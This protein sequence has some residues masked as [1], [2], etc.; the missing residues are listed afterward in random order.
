[1]GCKERLIPRKDMVNILSEVFITDALTKNTRFSNNYNR[2][3]SIEYYKPILDK[4]GYTETQF[5]STLDYYVNNLGEFEKLM[6]KVV[7]NLSII[8]TEKSQSNALPEESIKASDTGSKNLWPKKK[9]WKWPEDGEKENLYFKI[10]TQGV[11]TYT[12][13]ALVVVQPDDQS[14]SPSMQA[15][16]Y[17]QEEPPDF[18]LDP[19][20]VWYQKDGKRKTV[21]LTFELT[22]TTMTHFVGY[23]MHH[24]LKAGIWK[25]EAEMREINIA[26]T[27]SEKEVK[28]PQADVSSIT[29]KVPFSPKFEKPAKR[30]TLELKPTP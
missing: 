26:F 25:K 18:Q 3:D 19:K 8:E 24:E 15:W 21:T 29:K 14:D 2:K 12:I 7:G 4:Y 16:F 9:Q 17:A 30:E 22:D 13:K 28:V 10:P 20:I 27:P 23:L 11:G 6:D 1:M 5:V